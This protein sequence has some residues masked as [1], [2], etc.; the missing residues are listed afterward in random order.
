MKSVFESFYR[1][2]LA[3]AQEFNKYNPLAEF[4][5]IYPRETEYKQYIKEVTESHGRH[6]KKD[7]ER[8][9]LDIE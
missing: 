4:L 1:G 7:L 9:F 6:L 2:I 5:E 8:K 3:V